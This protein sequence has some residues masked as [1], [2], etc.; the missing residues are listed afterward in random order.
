MYIEDRD[1][2][3]YKDESDSD[4][5]WLTNIISFIGNLITHPQVPDTVKQDAFGVLGLVAYRDIQTAF[6]TVNNL[7]FYPST[8]DILS[9]AFI[10][11]LVS[12]KLKGIYNIFP[13]ILG[14]APALSVV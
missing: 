2:N 5:D 10:R 3:N 11:A 9:R 7:I 12:K 8:P 4:I 13:R 6:Q 1:S 14:S